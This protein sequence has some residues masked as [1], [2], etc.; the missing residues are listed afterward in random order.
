MQNLPTD[1][2]NYARCLMPKGHGYPM[3]V[4]KPPDNL[5]ECYRARGVCLGD[6]GIV[7]RDGVFDFL[8]SICLPSDH[9]INL[10]RTPPGFQHIE[11]NSAM[12]ILTDDQKHPVGSHV[13]SISVEKKSVDGDFALLDNP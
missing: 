3:W 13:G 4:P 2:E 1:S 11:L 8:F 12:D 5:P 6:I 7:T 10:G 9:A